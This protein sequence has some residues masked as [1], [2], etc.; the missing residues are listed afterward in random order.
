MSKKLN[1]AGLIL[2]EL[3]L[4]SDERGFF[5]ERYQKE[6]FQDLGVPANFI[7]DNHSRSKTGVIRGLHY[8][9]SP[10]QGKLVGVIR[11]KIWDVV[12]DIR[13]DS[14]TYGKWES[15]ELSD[16]NGLVLWVPGGFAHGFCVLGNEDADVIY[17]VDTPYSP[18]TEG[19]ISFSD[20]D[21]KIHWPVSN[22]IVS[23]KD[24]ILSS[25]ADYQKNPFF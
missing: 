9:H 6:R 11:G 23:G 2:V 16:E 1:L 3:K 10:S 14:P 25:F 20:P 24:Q 21:L 15:V 22:P 5:T 19:G 7:Q 4:Y 8:Q 17:K 12:V 13:K 18:K